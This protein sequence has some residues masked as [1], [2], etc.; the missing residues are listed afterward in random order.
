MTTSTATANLGNSLRTV[1]LL[2]VAFGCIAMAAFL[3]VLAGSSPLLAVGLPAVAILLLG[4]AAKPEWAVLIGVAILYSN[5]AVVAARIHGIPHF[6]AS[7]VPM[8]FLVPLAYELLRRRRPLIITPQL[9]LVVVYLIV[10]MLGTIIAADPAQASDELVRFALEGAGLFFVL[11]QLVRTEELLR[12]VIWVLLAVGAFLGGLS[13]LQQVTGTFDNNYL[14]FA[15]VIGAGF[16]P[17]DDTLLPQELQP[18]VAGSVGET[19]RYAQVLLVLFPLG[20]FRIWDER[21]RVARLGAAVATLLIVAGVMLTFSRGAAIGF[22]LTL[23][24]ALLLRWVK[25]T[26]L[27]VIVLGLIAVLLFAPTYVFRLSSIAEIPGATEGAIGFTAGRDISILQRANS[28]LA[29]GVMFSEHPLIGVGPG[30]Y[31]VHYRQYASR[32][33]GLAGLKDYEAHTLYLGVAAESGILGSV[34]FGGIL[35]LTFRS[36]ARARRQWL[37]D[38]PDLANTASAFMLAL[39]SY[40]ATGLFLHMAYPRY[41]WILIALAVATGVIAS[42]SRGEEA[43]PSGEGQRLEPGSSGQAGSSSRIHL[44]RETNR[45]GAA[46]GAVRT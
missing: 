1:L 34:S 19:N 17:G 14:G 27:S 30:Q 25:L 8:I 9:G 21:S 26:H 3:S 28:T 35:V 45:I 12:R 11:T 41:L 15:Q 16:R 31:S 23:L 39:V 38:R 2:G 29:A 7:A 24:V 43:G 37:R 6:A 4:V 46:K 42:Q 36:L 32:V 10:Q 20:F 5:A 22:A 13:L 33:G 44:A 18:R 40:L